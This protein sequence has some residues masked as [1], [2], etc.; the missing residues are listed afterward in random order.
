MD[1]PLDWFFLHAE[2][3]KRYLGYRRREEFLDLV[4]A[5]SSAFSKEN[6]DKYLKSLD[7]LVE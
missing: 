5:I 7:Q 6:G 3:A 2:S 4:A 1:L